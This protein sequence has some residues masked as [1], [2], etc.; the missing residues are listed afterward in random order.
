MEHKYFGPLFL[1]FFAAGVLALLRRIFKRVDRK[2]GVG[3]AGLLIKQL[4]IASITFLFCIPFPPADIR[5]GNNPMDDIIIQIWLSRVF[6][7]WMGFWFVWLPIKQ[8]FPNAF[9]RKRKLGSMKNTCTYMG[10]IVSPLDPEDW[11]S[12]A[13]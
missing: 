4:L 8:F 2:F 1:L 5:S 10:D 3:N 13:P 12:M 6:L 9:R 7:V 11:G